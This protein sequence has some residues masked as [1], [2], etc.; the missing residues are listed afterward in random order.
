MSHRNKTYHSE[1]SDYLFDGERVIKKKGDTETP[2]L[3]AV[4]LSQKNV[5]AIKKNP[6]HFLQNID[7]IFEHAE[8]NGSEGIICYEAGDGKI[9]FSGKIISRNPPLNRSTNPRLSDTD[10][11]LEQMTREFRD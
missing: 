4:Y 6:R 5:T 10:C 1:T 8:Y 9:Y 3:R 2:L 11:D 7:L